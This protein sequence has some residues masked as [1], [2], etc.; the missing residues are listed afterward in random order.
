MKVNLEVKIRVVFNPIS[1]K[2]AGDKINIC[3]FL[4]EGFIQAISY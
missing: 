3:R 1:T 2:K 4:N